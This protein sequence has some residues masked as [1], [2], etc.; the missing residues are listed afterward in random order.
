M[1]DFV[2]FLWPS[3]NIWTVIVNCRGHFPLSSFKCDHCKAR[4]TA[5]S[6]F[7]CLGLQ[8][9]FGINHLALVGYELFMLWWSF[10]W[11]WQLYSILLSTYCEEGFLVIE[12]A[13]LY[14]DRAIKS[15]A[16]SVP[17]ALIFNLTQIMAFLKQSCHSYTCTPSITDGVHRSENYME[18]IPVFST[19]SK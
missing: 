16:F 18:I 19:F 5:L 8:R 13:A 15:E 3:Q 17:G 10:G 14:Q 12:Y 4:F 6:R 2:I 11:S 1:S 7:L 9:G